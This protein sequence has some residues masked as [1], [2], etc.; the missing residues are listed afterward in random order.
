MASKG[1]LSLAL[2]PFTSFNLL[3]NFNIP[4]LIAGTPACTYIVSLQ[5]QGV[6]HKNHGRSY[7]QG[8]VPH[9]SRGA[10]LFYIPLSIVPLW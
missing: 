6:V 10:S 9:L 2:K 8:P 7:L 5:E 3:S 1:G 4:R